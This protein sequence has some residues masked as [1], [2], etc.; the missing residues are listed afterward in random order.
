MAKTP[1]FAE[2]YG[3]WALVAGA[4]EGLGEALAHEAARR[5]LHVVLVARRAELLRALAARIRDEYRVDV[6]TITADLALGESATTLAEQTGDIEVGL[7]VY[8]A[9]YSLIGPFLEQSLEDHAKE[10]YVNC[11][12]PLALSQRF[13]R[14]MV[15]RKRGGIILMSS[16]SG[17]QGSALIANYAATKAY[18]LVLAEGLWDEFRNEGVSVMA[19]CAGATR[20]PNY[21]A[22]EPQK[23][24]SITIP[25]MEPTAVAKETFAALG[26]KPSFIPGRANRLAALFM[27]RVMPRRNAVVIMG[28]NTRAMYLR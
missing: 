13:G 7:L 1:G 24:G 2:R 8:N 17:Y 6:R 20:T 26:D 23:T 12:G 11:L 10:V 28:K 14:K 9:A 25:V 3:P 19:S 22:S 4:S 27:S 5:G 15:E 16:M 21:E 18:N